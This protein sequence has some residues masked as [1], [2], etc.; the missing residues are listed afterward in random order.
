MILDPVERPSLNSGFRD[1][2]IIPHSVL[3]RRNVK[4][5]FMVE[6]LGK[7][8]PIFLKK[9]KQKINFLKPPFLL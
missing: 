2:R 4:I 5:N 8:T 1:V 3:K 7:A 9:I 6:R